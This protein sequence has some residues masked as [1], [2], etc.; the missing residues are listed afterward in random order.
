EAACD[1]RRVPARAGRVRPRSGPARVQRRSVPRRLR[2]PLRRSDLGGPADPG[3]PI[4]VAVVDEVA[5]AVVIE[6]R[7]VRLHLAVP[8]AR[9]LDAGLFV[10]SVPRDPVVGFGVAD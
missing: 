10:P 3:A 1:E 2:A 4:T 9:A 5:T 6:H 8:L 7:R